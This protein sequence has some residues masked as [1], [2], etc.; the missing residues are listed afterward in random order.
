MKLLYSP[1]SPFARKVRVVIR[2]KHLT[3]RFQ[4]FVTNPH[5]NGQE[6]L[7]LNPL[8]KV[9]AVELEHG[10]LFDSP[11]LCEY[12]DGLSPQPRLIPVEFLSRIDVLRT[13]A[14]ADGIM[15]AAVASVLEK[16]RSDTAPSAHWLARWEAAMR[17]SVGMMSNLQLP[18]GVRL[19]GIA[20]ACALSYLDYRFPAIPWRKEY[21]A[22]AAWH[23]SYTARQSFVETAPPAQ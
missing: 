6:L 4:E 15:D 8:A 23:A 10:S 7:A 13:Q 3:A 1:G 14:L 11:L 18:D 19:D 22:L 12:L 17:R 20:A 9:P 21:P 2:E 5:D 16:R